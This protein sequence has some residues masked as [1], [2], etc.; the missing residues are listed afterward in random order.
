MYFWEADKLLAPAQVNA[1]QSHK[2]VINAGAWFEPGRYGQTLPLA[3]RS[4]DLSP[5]ESLPQFG[6]T[7]YT[8]LGSRDFDRHWDVFVLNETRSGL[9]N[10]I[11]LSCS[12]R[13]AA[14]L[15]GQ[16]PDIY[17]NCRSHIAIRNGFAV[18]VDIQAPRLEHA[19]KIFSELLQ[20]LRSY[21]VKE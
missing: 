15:D 10:E 16:F 19:N 13:K 7:A 1:T 21:V 12:V 5:P 6:L 3:S 4:R 2:D 14:L 8:R 11:V 9:G 18:I 17:N 20:I